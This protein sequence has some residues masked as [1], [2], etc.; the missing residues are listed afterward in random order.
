MGCRSL[1][2]FTNNGN[3]PCEQESFRRCESCT[4]YVPKSLDSSSHAASF[5]CKE[6]LWASLDSQISWLTTVIFGASFRC[7]EMLRASLDRQL[8]CQTTVIFEVHIFADLHK[9]GIN[10]R[11]GSFQTMSIPGEVARESK[12]SNI[13]MRKCMNLCGSIFDWWCGGIFCHCPVILPLLLLLLSLL[14]LHDHLRPWHI[15]VASRFTRGVMFN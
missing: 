7:K 2:I 10:M 8:F 6:M 3:W 5:R 9:K 14:Q 12:L 1:Q 11:A 15:F 13:C 4:S